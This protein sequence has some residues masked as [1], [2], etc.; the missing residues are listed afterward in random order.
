M[1][2]DN[3]HCTK[4]AHV[5]REGR[6]S[7]EKKKKKKRESRGKEKIKNKN[8]NHTAGG[9]PGCSGAARGLRGGCAGD[10]RG[11]RGVCAGVAVPTVS[12]A[13]PWGPKVAPSPLP[14]PQQ[15]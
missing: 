1:T 3:S 13:A 15:G 5:K 9:R 2:G 14:T 12:A 6:E 7:K 10:A 4:T 11:L 8:K